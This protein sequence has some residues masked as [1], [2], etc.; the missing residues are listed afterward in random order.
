MLVLVPSFMIHS[1]GVWHSPGVTGNGVLLWVSGWLGTGFFLLALLVQTKPQKDIHY[2][3]SYMTYDL[4]D[5][6]TSL[7]SLFCLQCKA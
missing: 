1:C 4:G 3:I 7:F 6:F 5:F 2:T